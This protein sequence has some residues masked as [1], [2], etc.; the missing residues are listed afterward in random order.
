MKFT[1]YHF[2]LSLLVLT[3]LSSCKN[4]PKTNTNTSVVKDQTK[5]IDTTSKITIIGKS[6]D[7]SALEY[8]NLM[9]FSNFGFSSY[10]KPEE[11]NISADSLYLNL[12]KI[13]QPQL[14]DLMAFSDNQDTIPYFTRILVTP[15]DSIF[16]NIKN[17]KITFSGKNSDH[18]NF[19]SAMND[20]LRQKWAVYQQD[21]N[22]Y[23][24]ALEITYKKKDAFLENYIYENPKVSNDFKN[25]VASELKYEYLYNLMLPRNIKD[26]LVKGNYTNSNNSILYE[27]AMNNFS[28]E[29]LFNFKDYFGNITVADFQKPELINNDYFKR[30]L[31]LYIRHYFVNH[32]YLD[33]SRKNFLDEKNFIQKNFDGAI[34]NYAIARLINDYYINGFGTGAQ[35]IDII[36]NLIKEYETPFAEPS[37]ATRMDKIS[38]NLDIYDFELPSKVMKEKLLT[39]SG[40]T[41]T[42]G[43]VLQNAGNNIKALDFWT[44]WCGP[45][46][47]DI[48]KSKR[49]R[50][51]ISTQKNVKFI[52]L[53][54]DSLQGNWKNRVKNLK[55]YTRKDQHFLVLKGKDSRI[56]NYMVNK[57]NKRTKWFMIPRYSILNHK[58]KIISNNAPR[59]SD[60][61]TFRKVIEQIKQ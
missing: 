15:G 33:Y 28:Q 26:N 6:D 31:V 27:Y 21:P 32:E 53:S 23:Q 24:T 5:T 40:D 48:Q 8:F 3:F 55:D 17:G 20:P 61:I 45:C 51:E 22:S 49:F 7:A 14:M 10:K 2:G 57:E 9:D 4:D 47:A 37:I 29:K 42:V 12:H 56:V 30:S 54:L 34:E 44:S 25:L 41:T 39:V 46:I 59:P 16:M 50:N 38:S 58:N 1:F 35:D 13:Q 11:R 43:E 52:Y 19:F 36:K 18:Y 60:S